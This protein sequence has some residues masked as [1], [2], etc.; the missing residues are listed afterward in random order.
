MNKEYYYTTTEIVLWSVVIAYASMLVLYNH[1]IVFG[2]VFGV[3]FR[4]LRKNYHISTKPT[5][6]GDESDV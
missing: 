6:E 5:D 1:P 3:S 2:L 4:W